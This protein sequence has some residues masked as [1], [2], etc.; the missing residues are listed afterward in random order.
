VSWR[1]EFV[2]RFSRPNLMQGFDEEVMRKIRRR[3]HMRSLHE[4][5]TNGLC[6]ALGVARVSCP[7]EGSGWVLRRVRVFLSTRS[8]N[9]R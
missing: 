3:R 6:Q 9:T 2:A 4:A 7:E 8:C 5:D 1:G